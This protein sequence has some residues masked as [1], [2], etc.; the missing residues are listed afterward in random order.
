VWVAR[1]AERVVL[2]RGEVAPDAG[3][4]ARLV[5]GDARQPRPGLAAQLAGLQRAVGLQ[6]RVL[7]GVAGVVVGAQ[8][9][10]RDVE[11]PRLVPLGELAERRGVTVGRERGEPFI[12]GEAHRRKHRPPIR[13]ALKNC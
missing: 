4:R 12:V 2:E 10:A 1:S 5:V 8:H 6:Q 9:R 11:Q 3:Q 7:H 13:R